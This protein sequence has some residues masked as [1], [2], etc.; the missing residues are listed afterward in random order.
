MNALSP[1]Q[2]LND[3]WTLGK[4]TDT[5]LDPRDRTR[6]FRARDLHFLAPDLCAVEM[7]GMG[8]PEPESH[9]I[10]AWAK[11]HTS[12]FAVHLSTAHRQRLF[13]QI[14]R[15]HDE[16]EWEEGDQPMRRDSFITFLHGIVVLKP[17]R[18]PS[19][20][21]THDGYLLASW[22]GAVDHVSA[23]FRADDEVRWS[24]TQ[25]QAGGKLVHASGLNSALELRRFLAPYDPDHWFRAG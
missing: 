1:T 11:Q 25:E 22:G 19:L 23:Q 14:D 17:T 5:W 3:A 9:E 12:Q 6:P 10:L 21:M 18:W 2:F 8:N 4:A 7:E 15:L 20:G 13:A 24:L 16:D